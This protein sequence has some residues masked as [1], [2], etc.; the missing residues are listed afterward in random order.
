ML[1]GSKNFKSFSR[2]LWIHLRFLSELNVNFFF[3]SE[4]PLGISSGVLRILSEIF[5][6]FSY[7]MYLEVFFLEILKEILGKLV[8]R[9]DLLWETQK[10]CHRQLLLF[11]F[12]FWKI[13]LKISRQFLRDFF[14]Y[15]LRN[16]LILKHF[17][18]E[19]L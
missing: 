5:V 18:K 15:Y 1:I 13:L 16:S 14:I 6:L 19:F 3:P 4:I 11:F 12:F 9:K 17:F 10:E 2:N 7:G 8:Y